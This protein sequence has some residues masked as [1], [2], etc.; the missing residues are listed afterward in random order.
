MKT[1]K[2]KLIIEN[3]KEICGTIN[4]EKAKVKEKIMKVE[5]RRQKK[6]NPNT[7]EMSFLYI[8]IQYRYYICHKDWY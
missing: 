2:G 6:R 3:F 8:N 4:E 7:I 1:E 5:N